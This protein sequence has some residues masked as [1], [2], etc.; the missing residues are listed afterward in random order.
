VTNK[1]INDIFNISNSTL[2]DWS[3][4]NH[5]RKNLAILLKSLDTKQVELILS[6]QKEKDKYIPKY[7]DTTRYISLDK[8][9]FSKDLFWSTKNKEKLNIKNIIIVYMERADQIDTDILCKSF[10]IDRVKT[11]VYNSK[12]DDKNKY[13]ALRQIDYF[14][15]KLYNRVFNYHDEL[16]IDFIIKPSQRVVDYFCQVNGYEEVEK[17]VDASN[18]TFRRKLIIKKMINYFKKEFRDD[19]IKECA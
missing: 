12:I 8:S 18:I 2:F 1:E 14:E 4:D 6:Y 3:N 13:E 16:N 15:S 7:K 19:T 5:N 9:I 10:G 11:T 17:E